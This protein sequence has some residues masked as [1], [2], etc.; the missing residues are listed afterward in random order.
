MSARSSRAAVMA[1]LLAFAA[2]SVP[3]A[4]QAPFEPPPQAPGAVNPEVTQ[5]NVG[6][7]ICVRRWTKTIRPPVSYT[8]R[9][10][11]EKLAT[12]G[13]A[14]QNPMHYEE[15]HRVPLEVGGHP[16]DPRNL[17]PEPRSPDGHCDG[18][19]RTA[20]CK[21]RLETFVHREVCARRMSLEEGRAIF[22]GDWIA[23]YRR[24][25]GHQPMPR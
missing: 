7:T 23:A 16:R 22:L 25:I 1:P 10:N 20:E 13:Y 2:I 11:R 14:D 5:E 4:A 8:N 21:D 18:V 3:A 12:L 6:E 19:H 24:H 15:D 9:L 17:F